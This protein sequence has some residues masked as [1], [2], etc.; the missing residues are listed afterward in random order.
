MKV[1][2]TSGIE[3]LD[4]NKFIFT[5]LSADAIRFGENE[6]DYCISIK[7]KVRF[8]VFNDKMYIANDTLMMRNY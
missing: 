2:A 8:K 6:L 3:V 5:C 1:L 4:A 7:E